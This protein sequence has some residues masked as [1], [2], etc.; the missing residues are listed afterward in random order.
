MGSIS[1]PRKQMRV[2]RVRVGKIT[3][4]ALER[5]CHPGRPLCEEHVGEGG[6]YEG[7]HWSGPSWV[8]ETS[9]ILLRLMVSLV[10]TADN[11]P[12]QPLRPLHFPYVHY[13]A[14]KTLHPSRKRKSLELLH[15]SFEFFG[16]HLQTC[17]RE[18]QRVLGQ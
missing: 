11:T 3:G 7:L 4:M 10:C 12:S 13:P 17:H 14:R 8:M 15:P 1:V 2:K 16:S 18:Q 9:P 5:G 6:T